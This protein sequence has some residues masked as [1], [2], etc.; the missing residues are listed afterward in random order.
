[1]KNQHDKWTAT[2]LQSG[3][4]LS[5]EHAMPGTFS[6]HGTPGTF[7]RYP[8]HLRLCFANSSK[9]QRNDDWA[10]CRLYFSVYFSP[11]QNSFCWLTCIC[12]ICY[13]F[14]LSYPFIYDLRKIVDH[15]HNDTAIQIYSWRIRTP[16]VRLGSLKPNI[17]KLTIKFGQSIKTKCLEIIRSAKTMTFLVETR[18]SKI[19][20]DI[21]QYF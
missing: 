7:L 1:M 18:L 10:S 3:K 13:D 4:T 14:F 20:H 21:P 15:F 11:P 5:T 9:M 8:G 16:I 12:T 17:I 6:E 2:S 19:M